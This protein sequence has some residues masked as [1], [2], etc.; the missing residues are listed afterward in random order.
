MHRHLH[1]S[2]SALEA[3]LEG[4]DANELREKAQ[5]IVTEAALHGISLPIVELSRRFSVDGFG[6]DLLLCAVRPQIRAEMRG[7][8]VTLGRVLE[9][10]FDDP[11]QQ[12]AALSWIR[13]DSVLVRN[14]FVELATES[15]NSVEHTLERELISP[16]WVA[17]FLLDQPDLGRT[18]SQLASLSSPDDLRISLAA[19]SV[20]R[21]ADRQLTSIVA[22]WLEQS[23]SPHRPR[24]LAI[25]VIGEP[26]SGKTAVVRRLAVTFGRLLLEVDAGFLASLQTRL[27]VW[28]IRELY[29]IAELFGAWVMVDHVSALE[30]TS[31]MMR[32]LAHCVEESQLLTVL[33]STEPIA[34]KSGLL[35]RTVRQVA[36]DNP[37]EWERVQLWSTHL[38][39]A[40]F[41][42][43]RRDLVDQLAAQFDISAAQI[44]NA[45]T[46]AALEAS[47]FRQS[48]A[49]WEETDF[50]RAAFRQLRTDP[51]TVARSRRVQLTFSDLVLPNDELELLR[52]IYQ[53]CRHRTELMHRWGARDRIAYGT[54]I[55]CLFSGEPGTGKTLAS[56]ILAAELGTDLLQVSLPQ[57]LSK[58][59][60]DTEKQIAKVFAEAK[61]A[62]AVLLFDEA[63]SLL[64]ARTDVRSSSDRYA[65]M[66]T[67]FLLQEIESF[68]GVV[69]LTTNLEE[70]LDSAAARR[71]LF[72]I[73]FPF[74]DVRSRADLWR[75]LMP[76]RAKWADDIDF[77]RLGQEFELSG[78]HIK[79]A[80][81][82]AAYQ[83]LW[84]DMPVD[85]ALLRRA[86]RKEC[87][88]IG[89]LV[90]ED[91]E[92][93]DVSKVMPVVRRGGVPDGPR[94]QRNLT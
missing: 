88:A 85:M 53:A 48:Q 58:W 54:G 67:N 84:H 55:V 33:M 24:F 31:P 25:S 6:M 13:P 37:G 20:T 21:E 30:P 76:S 94:L 44:R 16:P 49:A 52:E 46:D 66:S 40:G 57:V 64:S 73:R 2:L 72:R 19:M 18:L 39:H 34:E 45:C 9:S 22:A 81:L 7:R 29:A 27:G 12:M 14:R 42:N 51:K 75:L 91:E 65:N 5:Q 61:A 92:D 17:A 71:I 3:R 70:N 78:G 89:K 36:L 8:T 47:V 60:G 74:P 32:T 93:E 50:E 43:L 77:G 68:E 59:V 79:N 11:L 83:A 41:G 86:A 4:A 56:Q 15:Q 23:G 80:V 62:R 69:I 26:G 38:D 63:D 1:L 82:R 35:A 28:A 90:I 10:L 87:R